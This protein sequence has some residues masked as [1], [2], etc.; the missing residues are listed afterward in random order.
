ML[1]F[2][3][4]V[5]TLVTAV[6]AKS[7]ISPPQGALIVGRGYH[8]TIQGA[9]D[10]LN[11][12]QTHKEQI[13]FIYPGIYHE[14]VTIDSIKSP[15][16]IYGYSNNTH[17]YAANQVTIVAGHSQKDRPH[18]ESTATLRAKTANFKLYNV[19]VVNSFG[20]GS[21]ALALSAYQN[22]QGYYACSF[23]GFQ[24]TVLA[25]K[26]SQL[27]TSCYI[28][29]ATDFIF[30]QGANA[31]FERCTIGV[32]STSVG[33]ITASGR[34]SEDSPSYYVFNRAIIGAAIGQKVQ[35]GLYYLG[36]PWRSHARVAFQYSF[37]SN[38][39]NSAGWSVWNSP[40]DDRIEHAS[41][42]ELGN[43]GP[44]ATG[45]RASFSKKL[46]H[47]LHMGDILGQSYTSEYYYDASY[48]RP[49]SAE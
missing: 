23:K 13:I 40:R 10:A 11:S 21:Q 44:G 29:G 34:N 28:E 5:L 47:E 48:V 3:T 33:Y 1:S 24:D 17:S 16:T 45:K 2:F 4:V 43:S 30:G 36:R 49:S 19:N 35:A 37:M 12:T 15:L 26:G 6:L 39:I 25:Q 8:T 42:G 20:E 18:N 32:L 38:V 31:W 14:Q 9:V 7:R 46:E 41:F 22:N 27:Y